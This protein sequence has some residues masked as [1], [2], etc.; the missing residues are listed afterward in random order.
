MD[1]ATAD[2]D[3]L[4][5]TSVC[6]EYAAVRK[7]RRR[8]SF[9]AFRDPTRGGSPSS[10]HPLLYS[11]LSILLQ[12]HPKGETQVAARTIFSTPANPTTTSVK[13]VSFDAA[14]PIDGLRL[15]QTYICCK[16]GRI[17]DYGQGLLSAT[18]GITPSSTIVDSIGFKDSNQC[19]IIT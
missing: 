11:L 12:T 1:H 2:S 17:A 16:Y 7:T 14:F 4:Q 5:W 19:S 3:R 8:T 13:K 18:V 6:F 9:A 15:W 10:L